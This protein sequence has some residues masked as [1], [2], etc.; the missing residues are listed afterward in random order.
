MHAGVDENTHPTLEA[1]VPINTGAAFPVGSWV[2]ISDPLRFWTM[3]FAHP[4]R[5]LV[6]GTGHIASANGTLTD[7][8]GLSIGRNVFVWV[9][10]SSACGL[11]YG[12]CC[13]VVLKTMSITRVVTA[14]AG[15]PAAVNQS[16]WYLS[17]TPA[18]AEHTVGMCRLFA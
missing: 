10:A 3:T 8:A 7:V 13:G 6:A 1:T 12:G 11:E 2:F 4:H 5:H 14:R 9:A 16:W 17:A 18:P 15:L